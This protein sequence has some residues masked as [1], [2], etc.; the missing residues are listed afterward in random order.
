MVYI[1][2]FLRVIVMITF[3]EHTNPEYEDFQDN[4]ST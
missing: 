1:H 3:G 4:S 2:I